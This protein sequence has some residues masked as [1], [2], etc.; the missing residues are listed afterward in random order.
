MTEA[1]KSQTQ[2]YNLELDAC[3]Y[4]WRACCRSK[5]QPFCVVR[6]RGQISHRQNLLSKNS[7]QCGYAAA[8]V[9]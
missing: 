1:V 9:R 8:A 4:W 6:T 2:A 3:M 7:S 5:T